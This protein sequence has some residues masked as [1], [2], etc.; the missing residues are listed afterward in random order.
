MDIHAGQSHTNRLRPAA[1][2]NTVLHSFAAVRPDV[3]AYLL[4]FYTTALGVAEMTLTQLTATDIQQD[5]SGLPC[6]FGGVD[7]CQLTRMLCNPRSFSLA[8]A[9]M[10][11]LQS[12]VVV[13]HNLRFRVWL[14][15]DN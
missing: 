7:D 15:A 6:C 3:K 13:K 1:V 9:N 14:A 4:W 11:L 12:R 5:V 8:A 10:P 2:N